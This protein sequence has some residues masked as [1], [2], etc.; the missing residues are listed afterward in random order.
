MDASTI[1]GEW[2]VSHGAHVHP[3]RFEQQVLSVRPSF[4]YS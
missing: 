4:S 1:A 2:I 3:I